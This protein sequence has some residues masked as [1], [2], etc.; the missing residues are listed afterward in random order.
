M[1]VRPVHLEKTARRVRQQVRRDLSETAARPDL[2][3]EVHPDPGLVPRPVLLD[4]RP[5]LLWVTEVRRVLEMA[6]RRVRPVPDLP[7][8]EMGRRR[9]RP[10]PD[11][12]VLEMVRRRVRPVPDLPVL[13]LFPLPACRLARPESPEHRQARG[14]PAASS[15][16]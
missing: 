9:V 11:R 6:R 15:A 10:V 1:A 7:V 8:L 16:A 14:D 5:V 2:L 3:M 12:L 4:P 13:V